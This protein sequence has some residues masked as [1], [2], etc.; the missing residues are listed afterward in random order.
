MV[1]NTLSVTRNSNNNTLTISY[2]PNNCTINLLASG[3]R[4]KISNVSLTF[5]FEV[6]F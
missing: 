4:Q 2:R 6:T 1:Y 5:Y 3:V